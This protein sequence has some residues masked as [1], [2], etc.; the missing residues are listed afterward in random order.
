M[1]ATKIGRELLAIRV[2]DVGGSTLQRLEYER[3]RRGRVAN[4]YGVKQRAHGKRR[5]ESSVGGARDS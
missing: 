5:Y 4:L 1:Q 3:L 2:P